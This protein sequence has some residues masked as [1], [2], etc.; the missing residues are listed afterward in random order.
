[1]SERSLSV[2]PV[3]EPCAG[4]V[5]GLGIGYSLAP[6]KYSL[7]RLLLLQEDKFDKIYSPELTNNMTVREQIALAN[8]RQ[9]RQD[10]RAA[11]SGLVNQVKTT[12]KNWIDNFNKVPVSKNLRETYETN[13]T[14]LQRAVKETNYVELNQ[15][16]RAAKAALKASPEDI[17]LKRA[18]TQANSDLA[19]AKAIIGT[20]IELYKDSVRNLS[21]ERLA[22]VK[23]EPVKY[24]K[25]RE[26]YHDFLSALARRR[27]MASSKL[28][29]LSNNK[30]LIK[31]YEA[32]SE[33][34]PKART[35]SALMGAAVVGSV[36]A[37]LISG[38]NRPVKKSA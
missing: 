24:A 1:M 17:N 36:T 15:R 2:S 8:V 12:A 38:L 10:Y 21:E 13:R 23:H 11:R 9:A 35:K 33:F 18:L 28:F 3:I 19:K 34:L 4:G 31:N 37:L 25:V 30:N 6:R 29:E 32:I 20:K 7:K 27:T 16:Y 5:I 14:N 22:K 26:A